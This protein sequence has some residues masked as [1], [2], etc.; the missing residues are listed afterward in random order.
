MVNKGIHLQIITPRGIKF[1]RRASMIIFRCIDGDTGILPGH[2]TASMVLGDGILR[3]IPQGDGP[4]EWMA[5]FGGIATVAND[6]VT[7][8]TS[9]AQ[10]PEE[11]DAARAARDK[12][13]IERSL[14]EIEDREADL[15][16]QS[17]L[18][19]LRR[20]LVRIEVSAYTED[21]RD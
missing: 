15:E 8:L 3:I 19:L 7:L 4:E 21:D 14:Q 6:T 5:V 2:E 20:A 13:Q 9:I 11:I 10:R 18:L 17:S 1:K 12:E 16:T